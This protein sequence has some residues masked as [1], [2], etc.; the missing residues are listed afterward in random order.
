M[1]DKGQR[2]EKVSKSI[3]ALLTF[4]V[5]LREVYSSRG[6]LFTDF[7]GL[8]WLMILIAYC[9]LYSFKTVQFLRRR[10]KT[11]LVASH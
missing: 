3:S 6:Q 7:V 2:L 1:A 9:V 10:G 8:A 4:L 11:G 5:A